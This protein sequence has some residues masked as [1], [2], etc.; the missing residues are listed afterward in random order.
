MA[1]LSRLR[2]FNSKRDSEIGLDQSVTGQTRFVLSNGRFN[3]KRISSKPWEHFNVYHWITSISW[4]QYFIALTVFYFIINF[5]FAN[6]YFFLGPDNIDGLP[7]GS[8]ALKWLYCFFFSAQ[9]I[10][11]VGYGG[12]HPISI[13]ASTVSAIESYLGLL[14]FALATGT[15]YSRF[16]KPHIKIKY[17]DK[18][19]ISPHSGKNALMFMIANSFHTSLMEVEA[20][21]NLSWEDR[22]VTPAK[23]R[24]TNLKLDVTKISMFA[25]NWVVVHTI[26]EESPLY[27]LSQSD[28]KNESV[29][30]FILIKAFDDTFSQTVYSRKSYLSTDMVWGAKFNVPY[31]QDPNSPVV[32]MNMDK[33]GDY[34]LVALN[35][36]SR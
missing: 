13:A 1:K 10:T 29:Q 15:L 9:T 16:S 27:E 35:P 30:I 8:K 2:F 31:H 25:T 33:V 22:T 6:I 3:V 17:S 36:L 19:I 5:I 14:I 20:I 32:L 12:M 26:D 34:E 23:R 18:I 11:T 4:I 24:F 7:E 28:C 21:V